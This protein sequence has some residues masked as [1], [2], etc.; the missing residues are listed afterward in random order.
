MLQQIYCSCL[1]YQFFV[2]AIFFAV[3]YVVDMISYYLVT[4]FSILSYYI[5]INYWQCIE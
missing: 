3:M 1:G 2:L 4:F 5:K